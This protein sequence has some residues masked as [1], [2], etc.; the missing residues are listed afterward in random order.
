MFSATNAFFFS[1]NLLIDKRKLLFQRLPCVNLYFI[2]WK[3][4]DG[5]K[6]CPSVMIDLQEIKFPF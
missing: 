4:D 6:I 1:Q 2:T 5:L 3:R